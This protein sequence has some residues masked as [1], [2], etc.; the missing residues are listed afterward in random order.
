MTEEIEQL[1]NTEIAA[2]L[3]YLHAKIDSIA[4]HINIKE[5]LEGTSH[6]LSNL[7]DWGQDCDQDDLL[8]EVF[9]K[10]WRIA[11]CLGEKE[12]ITPK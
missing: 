2:M 8:K 11:A 12:E 4:I 7:V 5:N 1:T 3:L 9:E 10:L 6:D